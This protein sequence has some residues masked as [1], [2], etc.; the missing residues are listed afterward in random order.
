MDRSV[1][2][3]Y[4]A[5]QGTIEQFFGQMRFYFTDAYRKVK[6]NERLRYLRQGNRESNEFLGGFEQL[7]LEAGGSAWEDNIQHGFLRN[8]LSMEMRQALVTLQPVD[9]FVDY[10]RQPQKTADRLAEIQIPAYPARPQG[11][12]TP[13]C[14]PAM[15]RL[16]S[17]GSSYSPGQSFPCLGRHECRRS[18]LDAR[19]QSVQV[20]WEDTINVQTAAG[21]VRR[22][23][24]ALEFNIPLDS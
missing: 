12:R 8:G 14:R 9:D 7:I 16:Y 22:A 17:H 5:A 20:K 3:E 23:R 13:E 19:T 18:G 6:A 1:W 15:L 21:V 2:K 11:P 4:R 24:I 10:C